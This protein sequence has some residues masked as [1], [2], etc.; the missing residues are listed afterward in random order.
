MGSRPTLPGE[1]PTLPGERPTQIWSLKMSLIHVLSLVLVSYV[2]PD[3]P[4]TAQ[5]FSKYIGGAGLI[6]L[7]LGSHTGNAGIDQ[8]SANTAYAIASGSTNS[9]EYFGTSELTLT[10]P[11]Y[12]N[13][14]A[15]TALPTVTVYGSTSG[16]GTYA[17]SAT[18]IYILSIADSCGSNGAYTNSN[19]YTILIG[20]DVQTVELD[21]SFSGQ[22]NK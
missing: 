5:A 12:P 21:G 8:Y 9:S 1:R 6:T 19:D 15:Y 18:Q 2:V 11:Y 7:S 13:N 20:A 22:A 16:M 17:S 14:D 10:N 3:P 4:K